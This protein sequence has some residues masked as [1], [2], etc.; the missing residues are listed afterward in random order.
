MLDAVKARGW[1]VRGPKSET[2]YLHAHG[3][4]VE[5][6]RQNDPRSGEPKVVAYIPTAYFEA[7]AQLRAFKVGL[8]KN[9][10]TV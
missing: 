8:P 4:R 7:E 6:K 1:T 3:V 2:F 5:L 10:G 9:W